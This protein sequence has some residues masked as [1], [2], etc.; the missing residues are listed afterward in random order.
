MEKGSNGSEGVEAEVNVP[1]WLDRMLSG[2]PF[3]FH[4]CSLFFC[5]IAI[6]IQVTSKVI[7]LTSTLFKDFMMSMH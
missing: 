6:Y 1:L 4:T 3:Y 7:S 5:I 2:I